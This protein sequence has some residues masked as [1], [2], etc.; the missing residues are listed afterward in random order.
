MLLLFSLWRLPKRKLPVLVVLQHTHTAFRRRA[1]GHATATATTLRSNVVNEVDKTTRNFLSFLAQLYIRHHFV[2]LRTE[3]GGG[4]GTA[5]TPLAAA[6]AACFKLLLPPL[7]KLMN[8]H[9][10]T[11]SFSTSTAVIGNLEWKQ[12]INY[13]CPPKI[14][15][16]L[17]LLQWWKLKQK[18]ELKAEAEKTEKLELKLKLSKN[19][20]TFDDDKKPAAPKS[21]AETAAARRSKPALAVDDKILLLFLLLLL[22]ATVSRVVYFIFTL[23]LHFCCCGKSLTDLLVA[24]Q[25]HSCASVHLLSAHQSVARKKKK[26]ES[27]WQVLKFFIPLLLTVR[28]WW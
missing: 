15:F 11:H 19:W 26:K 23:C 3:C 24:V 1:R 28:C 25:V 9:S 14:V 6:A 7:C 27:C 21:T 20:A 22:L 8:T 4:G 18:P 2:A 17:R 10:L 5:I 13:H 12:H 16:P